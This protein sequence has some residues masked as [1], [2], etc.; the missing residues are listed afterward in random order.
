MGLA[1]R[2]LEENTES[3]NSITS[4]KTRTSALAGRK[5]GKVVSEPLIDAGEA[6]WY[7]TI[8]VGTPPVNFTSECI[9]SEKQH[10]AD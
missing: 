2:V 10:S 8:S 4:V 9:A 5:T 3:P 7:G 1:V 6:Y